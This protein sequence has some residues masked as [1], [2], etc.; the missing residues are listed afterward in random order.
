MAAADPEA[1]RLL[2]RVVPEIVVNPFRARDST[3]VVARALVTIDLAG[4]IDRAAAEAVGG[5]LT[6]TVWV[7]LFDPPA[8]VIYREEVLALRRQG[9]SERE[10]AAALGIHLPTVQRAM[11]LTRQMAERGTADPYELLTA[12][13]A[14]DRKFRRHRH[15]RYRFDPRSGYPAW[16]DRKEE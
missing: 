3:R 2:R 7:D 1:G 12:P 10:T 15:R 16:P 11:A 9:K 13:P 14:D 4:L 5:L 8:V 6:S